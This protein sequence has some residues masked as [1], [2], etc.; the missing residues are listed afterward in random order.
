MKCIVLAIILG[1]GAYTFLTLHYR[2]P[3]RA[4]QPYA[5]LKDRANTQRLLGAGYQRIALE[6]ELPADPPAP[7]ETAPTAT[8][9]AGLPAPLRDTLV[10]SPALPA[11]IVSVS[12]APAAN[13]LLGYAIGFRCTLADNKQQLAGANLYVRGDEIVVAPS[14]D[15][16]S[17]GLLSRSRES[18]VRVTIPAGS[19]KPGHYHVT[20]VGAHGSRSWSLQ[21]H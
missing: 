3:G 6:A 4:F 13:A 8:A 2:K 9:G 7:G 11:E 1:I 10:D 18:L 16:L 14:F 21:V 15:R 19:L 12:A 20:L 5:D 17:G